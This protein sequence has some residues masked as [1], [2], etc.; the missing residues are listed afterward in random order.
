MR[1]LMMLLAL[2]A[3][4]VPVRALDV[5]QEEAGILQVQTAQEALPGEAAGL[6]E[7]LSPTGRFSFGE[8]L[9]RIVQRVLAGGGIVR[10]AVRICARLL[11]ICLAAAVVCAFSQSAENTAVLAGTLGIVLLC[12][13]NLSTLMGLAKETVSEIS[14]YMKLLLPVLTAAAAA[15][16][17]AASS[18]A[19]Y[20]GSAAFL[21][22]LTALIRTLV[23]PLIFLFTGLSA[24]ECA[25][26]ENRL[27]KLRDLTGQAVKWLLKGSMSLFTGYL[28]LTGLLSGTADAMTMKAAK[29]VLSASLP[30]VGG[31]VSGAAQSILS[32]A[33]LLRTTVGAYGMLAVLAAGLSPFLRLGTQY[34][35]LKLTAAVSAF[36]SVPKLSGLLERMSTAMGFLL[37]VCGCAM[38]M[39]LISAACFIKV[40]V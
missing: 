17:A 18:A 16:G 10:P 39:A 1:K 23:L 8:E 2:L 6:M 31:I 11:G 5:M 40:A 20:T 14:E 19:L 34:L 28:A 37:S 35:A 32:S 25:L 30:V 9:L 27:G 38:L 24:A 4:V 29:S 26:S 33:G 15:S 36:L 7:G 22:I 13:G 3:S 12:T 21:S